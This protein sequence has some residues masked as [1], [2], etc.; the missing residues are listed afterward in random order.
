MVGVV[1]QSVLRVPAPWL[2]LDAESAP[3]PRPPFE[4]YVIV[5]S[6]VL[7]GLSPEAPLCSLPSQGEH[8]GMLGVGTCTA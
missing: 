7:V 5:T 6:A 1:R 3:V 4:P 8:L 2:L